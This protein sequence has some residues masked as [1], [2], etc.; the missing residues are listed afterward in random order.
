M[1]IENIVTTHEQHIYNTHLKIQRTRRNQPFKYRK[2][3][4]NIDLQTVRYL[5]KISLFL[6]K[7][8]HID[9]NEF[10]IAPFKIYPDEEF[11]NLEYYTTL[12]A[13]KAYTL[14]Q[15]KLLTLSPDSQD[16][17]ENIQKSLKFILSF[18]NTNNVPVTEY[19]EH[20]TNNTYSF[21]LHLK[22]HRVNV[23]CLFGFESFDKKIKTV[24]P[25]LLSFIIGNDL[26]VNLPVFRTKYLNSNKAQ[27]FVKLGI[28]KITQ[29]NNCNN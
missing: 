6:A 5:Q 10:I 16:Q 26:I 19:I 22:E 1:H 17:L 4:S 27:K 12:K 24:D 23:Y 13:T 11:F 9:L 18:C 25:D 14:Y 29:K 28:Q 7:H 3:F 2:D 21:L 15:Q 8:S 20:K